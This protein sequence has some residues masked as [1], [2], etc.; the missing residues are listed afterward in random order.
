MRTVTLLAGGAGGAKLA[1]GI[2]KLE[3]IIFAL[4]THENYICSNA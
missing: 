2:N 4:E 3:N 1:K